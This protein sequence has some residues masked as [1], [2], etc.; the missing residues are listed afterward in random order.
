MTEH[1]DP[2]DPIEI[3]ALPRLGLSPGVL[4][5]VFVGGAIGTV[6]RFVLDSFHPTPP[7][8]FP[9]AT[10]IINLSG[11]LAIGLLIP[12]VE[13]LYA[14]LPLAR[15]FLV[16][17]IL[18]GWTTFSTLVVDADLLVRSGNLLVAL[19]YLVAT[20]IGGVA[21]VMVG[22]AAGERLITSIETRSAAE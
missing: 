5:A 18:G 1:P 16:V 21:L 10:L 13:A 7:G 2:V 22:D 6:S 14:R 4:L 3:T 11:S 12:V 8:H 19:G 17:G 9:Y 15:P 20:L